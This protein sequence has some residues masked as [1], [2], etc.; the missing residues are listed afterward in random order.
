MP[1]AMVYVEF[2]G[3][4][5]GGRDGPTY[6][7]EPYRP[8]FRVG[9]GEYLGVSFIEGPDEPV[10]PGVVVNA[11]VLFMY[12]P[13]ISYNALQVGTQFQ[14]LEG[15]RIVGVGKVSGVFQ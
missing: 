3:A 4:E 10:T 12:S 8:H 2:I 14:V 11:K 15:R 13:Q 9:D 1:G 7:K 5:A 6:I